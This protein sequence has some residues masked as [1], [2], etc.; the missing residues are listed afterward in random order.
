M[1]DYRNVIVL[2]AG[3]VGS[4]IGAQLNKHANVTLVGRRAHVDEINEKG[5]RVS[6]IVEDCAKVNAITRLE[7][8]PSNCLL[9]IT[10]K[11]YDLVEAVE[12]TYHLYHDDT[13]ILLLQNGLGN[14]EIVRKI[15]GPNTEVVRALASMGVE[16][17]NSGYI[18][19]KYTGET[20]LPDTNTGRRIAQL[21]TSCGLCIHLS[22]RMNIEIWRK[23]VMNCVINPLTAVFRV[24]NDEI[25]SDTLKDVREGIVDECIRVAEKEG[26]VF[27]SDLIGVITDAAA[28]YRNY[29][30]MCQDVIKGKRTEIEFLNGKISEL[31]RKHGVATPVNDTVSAMIRFLEEKS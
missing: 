23:L 16:Y 8:V 26:V 4:Y 18:G 28:K 25:I 31:G 1:S 20:I 22:N 3:A 10:T 12:S 7:T 6:G 30:S 2:G 14:E 21:F 19:V 27:D 24:P 5:L 17:L 29:S 11:A 13:T 15:T 9:I